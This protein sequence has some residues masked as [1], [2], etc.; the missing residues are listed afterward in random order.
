MR[1]ITRSQAIEDL[2]DVLLRMVDEQNSLC[3]VASWRKL[4]CHGFAQWSVRELEGRFPSLAA[5]PAIQRGHKEW[6]AN[7]LQ[8]SRQDIR[9]R[10]LPCDIQAG[11]S[12]APCAGWGEFDEHE[13]ARFHREICGEAVEVV[14]DSHGPSDPA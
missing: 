2:R 14:P 10:L 4:F 6:L 5:T 12:G 13:L 11:D 3:R 7:E 1:R 9:R 8:L